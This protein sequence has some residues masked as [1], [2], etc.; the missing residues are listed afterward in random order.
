MSIIDIPD[1]LARLV[2]ST[3]LTQDRREEIQALG[4]HTKRCMPSK[5]KMI[6]MDLHEFTLSKGSGIPD[7]LVPVSATNFLFAQ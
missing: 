6:R 2:C 1:R 7:A 4:C 5:R 3:T